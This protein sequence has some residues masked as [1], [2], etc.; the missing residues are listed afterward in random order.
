M[1]KCNRAAYQQPPSGNG[2]ASCKLH[3]VHINVL[4]K[5]HDIPASRATYA[6]DY[7]FG[8]NCCVRLYQAESISKRK[9]QQRPVMPQ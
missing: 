5:V 4:V 3:L 7:T 2:R 1:Y 6:A 8:K 9:L